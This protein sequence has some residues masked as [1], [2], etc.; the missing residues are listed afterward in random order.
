MTNSEKTNIILPEIE[1]Y[2]RF[3]T[4]QREAVEIIERVDS[5]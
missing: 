1:Y 5:E 2:L 4:L 3:D